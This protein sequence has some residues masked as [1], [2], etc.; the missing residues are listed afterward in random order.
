MAYTLHEDWDFKE[1]LAKF[2]FN[3]NVTYTFF[4]YEFRIPFWDLELVNFFKYLP[5]SAKLNKYLYDDILC[6]DIFDALEVNFRAEL[7]PTEREIRNM[8]IKNKVK[9]IIPD[10]VKTMLIDR[11]DPIF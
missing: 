3:S 10:P 6:N 8:K 4:G 11:K 5:L 7:Q 9:K 1:K 2:N